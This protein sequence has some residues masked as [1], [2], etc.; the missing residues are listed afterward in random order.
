MT[1]EQLAEAAELSPDF[2]NKVELGQYVPS[3]ETIAKIA[4][5]LDV[6]PGELFPSAARRTAKRE[7]IDEL[8]AFASSFQPD[9]VRYL[10]GV[11]RAAM[12]FP[13]AKAPR[14]PRKPRK[15]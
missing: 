1:I 4:D 8:T 5:A 14:K 10:L 7:A 6:D 11:A 13:A 9:E 2:L 3:A 15:L 12:A